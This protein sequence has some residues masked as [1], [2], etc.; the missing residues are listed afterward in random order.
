MAI[1]GI[2]PDE[3][4]CEAYQLDSAWFESWIPDSE[5]KISHFSIRD[6]SKKAYLNYIFEKI[7]CQD[8]YDW[9]TAIKPIF[10]ALEDALR[11]QSR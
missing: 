2:F 1:E 7:E 8:N 9:L 4:I 5:G 3:W 6:K 11:K 10:N